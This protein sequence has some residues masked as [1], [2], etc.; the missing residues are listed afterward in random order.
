[1]LLQVPGLLI[2][3]S[4]Q[5]FR[6]MDLPGPVLVDVLA[7]GINQGK[8]FG[9]FLGQDVE[10][11]S[12]GEESCQLEVM[13]RRRPGYEDDDL[14][15]RPGVNALVAPPARVAAHPEQF[16][17]EFLGHSPRQGNLEGPLPVRSQAD[18][19]RDA[20]DF[21]ISSGIVDPAGHL[22]RLG[23]EVLHVHGHV[24]ECRQIPGTARDL[25]SDSWPGILV[26]RR[27]NKPVILDRK[28][29]IL[30]LEH[31]GFRSREG[32]QQLF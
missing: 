25:Q 18:L 12:A 10:V 22:D 21:P 29:D 31:Y 2:A 3:A 20:L 24:L 6:F 1:M 17:S 26:T 4:R 5:F 28:S 13:I 16:A 8:Q 15:D 11:L 9:L 23:I 7:I 19:T 14:L 32:A 30:L 27:E